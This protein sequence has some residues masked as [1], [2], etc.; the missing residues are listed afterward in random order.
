MQVLPRTIDADAVIAIGRYLDE[1]AKSAPVSIKDELPALRPL[2][3]ALADQELLLLV[4]EMC[5]TR[6]LAV[7]FNER[8]D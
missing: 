8:A 4:V 3:T 2:A 6:N 1:H 7:L 5:G